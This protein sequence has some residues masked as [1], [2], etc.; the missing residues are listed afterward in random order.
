MG[1]DGTA[2]AVPF[3]SQDEGLELSEEEIDKLSAFLNEES[4]EEVAETARQKRLLKKR[5]SIEEHIE[6]MVRFGEL[7]DNPKPCVRMKEEG[8]TYMLAARE[9]MMRKWLKIRNRKSRLTSFRVNAVQRE[10]ARTAARKSIVLK[11]RQLGITT[12]VAAR[13]FVHS[14]TR[15]GTLCVQ[16]AH[17]QGSAEEIF[18]MVHRF[19]GELAGAVAGRE[20]CARRAPMSAR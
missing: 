8:R 10:Y 4:K 14:I 15:P 5:K 3:Q 1:G 7:L 18:R 6:I 16:V 9:A 12:Y 13:F 17:D 20:P 19:A 11:A 2:E